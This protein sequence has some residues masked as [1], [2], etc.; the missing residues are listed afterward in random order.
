M[1]TEVFFIPET[2]YSHDF[3]SSHRLHEGEADVAVIKHVNQIVGC[4]RIDFGRA[5]VVALTETEEDARLGNREF[6]VGWNHGE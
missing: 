5:L 2:N 3:L 1:F 6:R 4:E